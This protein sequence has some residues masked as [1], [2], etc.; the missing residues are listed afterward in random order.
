MME[1]MFR[2]Q[3][4][5]FGQLA[6]ISS[7]AFAA[8]ALYVN[9][10]QQP[11]R[12]TLGDQAMLSEWKASYRRGL[13]M[14]APLAALGFALG[15]IAW[16]YSGEA[17]F[18]VG[19][20]LMMANWPWTL[21]VMRQTNKTLMAMGT[22]NPISAPRALILNWGFLHFA[23]TLFGLLATTMFFIACNHLLG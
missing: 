19:A 14:Q 13:A 22:G 3:Q 1:W 10:V 5:I 9:V 6:L 12:L 11:A 15:M 17:G 2:S 20:V 7:S 4:M 16:G 18:L 8:V 21:I 23:R